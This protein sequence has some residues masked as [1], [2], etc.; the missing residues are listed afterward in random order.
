MML[1]RCF[2]VIVFF[3]VFFVV[4]FSD[5]FFYKSIRCGYSFEWHRQIDA[6]QVDTHNICLYKEV[7]KKYTGCKLTTMKLLDCALIQVFAVIRSNK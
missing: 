3:V 7:V 4:F 5:Y 1:V 2:C 6:I